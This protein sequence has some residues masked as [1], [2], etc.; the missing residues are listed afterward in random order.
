MPNFR[1]VSQSKHRPCVP[2]HAH[3]DKN[4]SKLWWLIKNLLATPPTHTHT[5]YAPGTKIETRIK[6]LSPESTDVFDAY[7][8]AG[9]WQQIQCIAERGAPPAAVAG[10]CSKWALPLQEAL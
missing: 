10:P 9:N 8:F 6:N 7:F 4:T 3:S 1:I 5:P 2:G